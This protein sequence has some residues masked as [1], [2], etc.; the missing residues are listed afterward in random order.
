M[1]FLKKGR[2]QLFALLLT[3][4][5]AMSAC[6]PS[7]GGLSVED[8]DVVATVYDPEVDFS[9][10]RTFAMPDS[11]VHLLPD[12][13]DPDDD[14]ISRSFDELILREVAQG[15]TDLGYV[16]VLEP[17]PDNPPDLYAFVSISTTQ[18]AGYVGYPWWGG[19]GWY[20][21]YPPGWGPGWG[22]G[23][24]WYGGGVVYSYETG[25]L[26]VDLVD[27]ERQDAPTRE[28]GTTW[29]GALNG[30]LENSSAGTATRLNTGIRQMYEQSAY[31]KAG[32]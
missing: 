6:Y 14:N 13:A 25:T 31:L 27:P 2:F 11:V 29:I 21:G 28:I 32:S 19:W 15:L 16:R 30:L 24:P 10:Y 12:D 26:F 4:S 22:P 5:L 1:H 18:W 20:G 3:A 9:N 23:Y 8:L 7:S 17:D